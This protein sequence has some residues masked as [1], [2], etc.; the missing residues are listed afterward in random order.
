MAYDE[1]DDTPGLRDAVR[2]GLPLARQLDDKSAEAEF[3]A[4][5][6]AVAYNEGR[7]ADSLVLYDRAA[8]Y[9]DGLGL[10]RELAQ[11]LVGKAHTLHGMERDL[12]A[13]TLLLKAYGLFETDG[14]KLWMANALSG[15]ANIYATDGAAPSEVARA[16]EYHRQAI[17]LLDPRVHRFGLAS[18]YYNIGVAYQRVSDHVQA[19]QHLEKSLGIARESRESHTLAHVHYRLG[20]IAADEKNPAAALAHLD[21]ALP[22]FVRAEKATML[23]MT[24]MARA[25]V[26]AALGQRTESLAAVASAEPLARRIAS[27]KRDVQFH[28]GSARVYAA[29]GDYGRAYESM[30]ALRSADRGIIAASHARTLA[31]QQARFDTRQRDTENALLRLESHE[32]DTRRFLF[33][34]ALSLTVMLV[35]L[36]SFYVV[37]QTRQ[38]RRF[39]NLAMRDD[40]TGLPNRRSILEFAENKFRG[41]RAA[42]KGFCLA[43][44]DLDHFK[45]VNDKFG[46]SVGDAVLAEFAKATLKHMRAGDRL[47]R[48]GGEEFMLVMPESDCAQI[49]G[50]FDRLREGVSSIALPGNGPHPP[51]TFSLGATEARDDDRILDAVIKRADEALYRAKNSGRDRYETG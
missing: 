28:E 12:E 47:G 26:L 29:L 33:A 13:M 16:I 31:E 48:F 43:L 37:R 44:L 18:H 1:M 15:I 36:L 35:L 11:V 27:P 40:L 8:A 30:L 46:H 39:A 24:H 25:R 23:F 9:A 45:D 50:V 2:R 21:E 38:N 14:D 34:L 5:E 42:D 49:Q 4:A 19:R 7:T 3:M 22:A 6:A 20:V 51:I 17:A 41:R 10:E 32:A